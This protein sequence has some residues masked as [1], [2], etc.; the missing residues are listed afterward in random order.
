MY[1]VTAGGGAGLYPTSA[2]W[3]MFPGLLKADGDGLDPV[4]VRVYR[5]VS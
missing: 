4:Y 5:A 3:E 1:I 2:G